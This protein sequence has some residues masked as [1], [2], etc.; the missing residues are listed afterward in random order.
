MQGD[1]Q[2]D[3]GVRGRLDDVET[4]RHERE[5]VPFAATKK[6]QRVGEHDE[7][8]GVE[9]GDATRLVVGGV[10]GVVDLV[11]RGIDARERGWLAAKRPAPGEHAEDA[12]GRT[13]KKG[14][15]TSG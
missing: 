11:E 2:R 3:G 13:K 4:P 5:R 14:L 8:G 15:E 6:H 7:H 1:V 9:L 12:G 10:E